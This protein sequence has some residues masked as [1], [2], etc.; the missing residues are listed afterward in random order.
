MRA[1]MITVKEVVGLDAGVRT[2]RGRSVI[3]GL[4]R[5]SAQDDR[6]WLTGVITI[7]EDGDHD[8]FGPGAVDERLDLLFRTL[9][10]MFVSFVGEDEKAFEIAEAVICKPGPFSGER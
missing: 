6:R 2:G 9:K 4:P 8:A 10:E 5:R 1:W 3:L 7:G